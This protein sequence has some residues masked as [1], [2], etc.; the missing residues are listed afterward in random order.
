MSSILKQFPTIKEV[1]TYLIEGTGLGGDYHNQKSEHWITGSPPYPPISNPMSRYEKYKHSRLSFGINVLGSFVVEIIATNGVKGVA[2][3]F[4]GPPACWLVMHHF[5]RFLIGADPRNTNMLWD[6]MWSASMYYGRKGLP[7]AVIS[8]VDLC[9]WDL[10]GKIRKEP[11]YL[12]I[13]GAVRPELKFYCTG[14]DPVAVKRQGFFG[15]KVPLPYCPEEPNSIQ[16]NV[17][18][19]KKHKESVGDFPLMVDCWMSLNVTYALQLATACKEAGVKIEWWEEVLHPDDWD[20]Y[21]RLKEAHP[22][23]KWTTGEHEYSRYGFRQLIEGRHIDILQPDVMWCGGL[24][25]LLRISA[26]ASAYDIAVVPHG[27]GPYSAHFCIT[28]TNSPF[29][30]YIANSPDGQKVHPVFGKLFSNEAQP[31]NGVM[32]V[33]QLDAPG[34]GLELNPEVKLT[35]FTGLN[36]SL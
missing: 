6:Q 2:T 7:I 1:N 17:E 26:L 29:S 3:G 5:Q 8:V 22:D 13:G 12:M 30:E 34:F 10:V 9:L 31:V 28:Q 33:S 19:L 15:S 36:A 32:K 11:V 18:F 35:K 14:P 23:L 16:K 24:T 21:K 25:E 4:G 20:G 27:S